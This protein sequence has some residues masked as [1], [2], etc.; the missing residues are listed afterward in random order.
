[1]GYTRDT[2]SKIEQKL[3][4]GKKLTR[5]QNGIVKYVF[6]NG[7]ADMIVHKGKKFYRARIM[8]TINRGRKENFFG[9]NEKESMAPQSKSVKGVSRFNREH[10]SVLYL[11]EEKYTAL[12]ELRPGKKTFVN[13]AEVVLLE[14]VKLADLTYGDDISQ[15]NNEIYDL[16]ALACYVIVNNDRENY[17]V[18]QFIGEK[19]KELGYDGIRY[20]SSLSANGRNVVL[21]D[22]KKARAESS[23][24]YHTHSVLYYA[25][26][27]FPGTKDILLPNALGKRSKEDLETFLNGILSK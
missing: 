9:L 26:E 23:K 5:E 18:T 21:F 27:A 1:M 22:P 12:A 19:I 2:W 11:A 4:Y 20:S 15:N 17:L 3:I 25:Q 16:M 10:E 6:E 8:K 14:S 13:I 24:V 7:N